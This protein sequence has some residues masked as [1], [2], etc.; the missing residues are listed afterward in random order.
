MDA[1][2]KK[3]VAGEPQSAERKFK[4]PFEFQ[5]FA[6]ILFSANEFIPTKDRT[7]GFYR[8]FDVLRFN[9]MFK[10][11]EQKPELLQE[12][13]KEVAGIFTWALEGLERLSQQNWIMTKSSYMEDCH[14]EFRRATNPLHLFI[15]EE[16]VVEVNATIDSK[17]LRRRY[18]KYCEDNGY[19]PLSDNKLGQEL[20]R[21]EINKSRIRT[22][23]GR[24][25]IYEGIRLLNS[26]GHSVHRMSTV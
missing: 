22:E 25:N 18:E 24:I 13:T 19:K 21:L 26:S 14:N 3:I 2:F 7:H 6:K 8:R 5:P 10:S 20:K 9:R 1:R 12:L 16:C 23:D 11:E 15:E 17:E 4:K